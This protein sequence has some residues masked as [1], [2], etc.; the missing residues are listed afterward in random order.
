MC[1]R[2][3]RLCLFTFRPAASI[4][5]VNS[6]VQ[7]DPH[8][9]WLRAVSGSIPGSHKGVYVCFVV[10]VFLLYRLKTHYLSHNLAIS[11]CNV[12]VFSI[13]NILHDL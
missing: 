1:G 7:R 2:Q 8:L 4:L 3:I 12:K 6:V 13:L 9:F 11:F 5:S 10:V